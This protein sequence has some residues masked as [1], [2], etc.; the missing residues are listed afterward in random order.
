MQNGGFSLE[1]LYYMMT[2]GMEDQ[3]LFQAISK[4]LVIVP[5]NAHEQSIAVMM[6]IILG[7]RYACQISV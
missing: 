1:L 6:K 7:E 2:A 3:I 5:K 4:K